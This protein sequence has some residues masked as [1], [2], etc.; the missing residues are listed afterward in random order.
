MPGDYR[1]HRA[2][3]ALLILGLCGM[4]GCASVPVAGQ[5]DTRTTFQ[6]H[7]DVSAHVSATLDGPIV[8]SMPSVADA[9]PLLAVP[10]SGGSGVPGGPRIALIDLDGLI[11]NQSPTGPYSAGENPVSAFR[12]KL[13]LAAADPLVWGVVL[14]INSAGGSVT[15]CDILADE[16]QRF[17]AATGK[18]VV[19]SLMDLGTAGAY[20]LAVGGDL[21]L[22]HPT[23]V[24]GGIG[25]LMNRYNLEDAMAQLNIRAEPIKSAPLIDMGTV[26]A[27]LDEG[28]EGLLQEL[29]DGFAARFRNRVERYRPRITESSWA[30]LDD[31]RVLSAPRALEL[32]LIDRIGYVPDA[33]AEA[34]RL[35]G[36]S[37]GAE[38]VLLQR[39]GYPAR[40]IYSVTPN[41]PIQEGLIP[42]S[43]PGLDRAKAP[44]FLY[45]WSVDPTI[46]PRGGN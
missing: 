21:I 37:S 28:A 10:V 9:G 5:I 22:A 42:F 45:L 39:A 23:T 34:E 36:L 18:P 24:T 46:L 44:T 31:G 12:E 43:Y 4:A 35:S 27:P 40:S 16:L 2:V 13:E 38:V 11:L 17:R 8:L 32:A 29:A 15:A 33:I 19:C 30:I 26:T 41:A 1:N 25:A 7:T 14:R 3:L 20:Y 6:G